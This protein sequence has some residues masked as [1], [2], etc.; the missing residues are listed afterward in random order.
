MRAYIK[1]SEAR[2]GPIVI[3]V[4]LLA[5]LLSGFFWLGYWVSETNLADTSRPQG[6]QVFQIPLPNAEIVPES[7]PTPTQLL[8]MNPEEKVRL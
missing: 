8:Q 6:E 7:V 3:S 4:A 5:G 2:F 1:V